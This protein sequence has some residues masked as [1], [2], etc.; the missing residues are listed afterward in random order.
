MHCKACDKQLGEKELIWNTEL[1]DG[2]G[3][4]ELCFDCLSVAMD[5]A[6]C[7]GF[8]TEDDKFIL[9]DDWEKGNDNGVRISLLVGC[10]FS[11]SFID[12]EGVEE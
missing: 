5:A 9:L 2:S 1:R 7:D 8:E 4:W 12:I 3:D 11:S 6:Y 10:S